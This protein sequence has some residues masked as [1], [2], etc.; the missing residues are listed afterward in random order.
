MNN[1]ETHYITI[2]VKAITN[3]STNKLSEL[4]V[5][6]D[7][8]IS[9]KAHL[10]STPE[11]GKANESLIKLLSKTLKVRKSDIEILHGHTSDRKTLALFGIN[12]DKL[13]LNNQ[14][15]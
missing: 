15:S 5:A 14:I 7:G 4:K 12:H 1:S 6:D 9:L 2:F 8:S 3:S 10:T 11:K 13:L